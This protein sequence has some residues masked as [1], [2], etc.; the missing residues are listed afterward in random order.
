ML[1]RPQRSFSVVRMPIRLPNAG[2]MPFGSALVG[3]FVLLLISASQPVYGQCPP[4]PNPPGCWTDC[5]VCRGDLNADGLLNDLDLL[6]FEIYQAQSPPNPCANFNGNCDAGGFPIVDAFDRQILLCIINTS[7]GACEAACGLTTRDCLVA[8]QPRDKNPGGCNNP[9]CCNAVCLERPLCCDVLWDDLCVNAAL[10]LCDPLG[11]VTRPDAGDCLCEHTYALPQDDCILPTN[12]ALPGC[13]DAKCNQLVCECDPA[14]CTILWD[15]SCRA[16]ATK[17]CTEA[18]TNIV[19]QEKVC[20]QLPTCCTSGVWDAPCILLAQQIIISNPGLQIRSFP[21]NCLLCPVDRDFPDFSCVQPGFRAILCQI[22]PA[23][24]NDIA[25]DT[26]VQDCIETVL[27]NFEECALDWDAGCAQIADRLCR[28]PGKGGRGNCLLASDIN[29]GC[30]DSYCTSIV[31]D[32]DPT[33]CSVTWDQSCVE[34]AGT[35]CVLVPSRDL[36]VPDLILPGGSSIEGEFGL[37]CGADSA[38]SCLYQNFTP[39]C[40][41]AACCQLVCGYDR[42]CCDSRWDTLCAKLATA[43]CDTTGSGVCGPVAAVPIGDYPPPAGPE[44]RSCFTERSENFCAGYPGCSPAGCDNPDCCNNVCYVDPYCCEIRW[45]QICADGADVLC[46]QNFTSCG[47]ILSGSCFIPHP[48]PYCDNGRCC[49]NVCTIE[50]T[51]CQVEWDENCVK[52][53]ET[54]CTQCGDVYSGSCLIPHAAP[55]CYDEECCQAVCEIDSFCCTFTWDSGCANIAILNPEQ[56]GRTDACGDPL[57]RGCYISSYLPGC[58]DDKCCTDICKN[59]DPWC[60]EVRWDAVCAAQAFTLCDPPFFIDGRDPCDQPSTNQGC[61]VPQCSAAVCSVPGYESCCTQRWDAHCVEAANWLCTGIYECP[62]TGDCMQTN[63]TPLCNDPACCNAVCTYD[64]VCCREVWDNDCVV[65]ALNICITPSSEPD[66]NCPCLGSCFEGREKDEPSPGCEDASCCS[67]VCNV[68][69]SCCTTNWDQECA[70]YAVQFCGGGFQCGSWTSGS[71]LEPGD[72]PFCNDPACCQAVCTIEPFCCSNSWDSFCVGYAVTRC[73]RGCGLSTSG[74][75]Y[76]PHLTP[77]CNEAECCETVCE[78]DPICCSVAWD[79]YCTEEALK[80]CEP[81]ECGTFAAGDCCKE[82]LTPSC[83]DLRCCNAI[84]KVDPICCDSTWDA[85]CVQLARE[86]TVN[87]ECSFEC[88]EPCAG[89]CCVPNFT[90]AC[91]DEDCCNAV[92]KEDPFCCETSWDFNCANSVAF[93]EECTNV[94]GACPIPVCGEA[95]SGNCCFPNGTPYCDDLDCCEMI[96]NQDPS[97]CDVAWDSICAATA[98]DPDIGCDICVDDFACGDAGSGD[99]CE[100]HGNPYCDDF[101][102]CQLVCAF[103]QLC[104]IGTWDELCV[105]LAIQNCAE[106]GGGFA[107]PKMPNPPGK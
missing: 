33:C 73:L 100:E 88:G 78:E 44:Y 67:A 51:C 42:F 10:N 104:C 93:Y 60:C 50:P 74:S 13:S 55:A 77:G 4:A 89:S 15:D 31:C 23:Y 75:C 57:S 102:C 22:D 36:A 37:S 32:C 18:C 47:F 95:G 59:Y 27:I 6:I 70:D 26:N 98:S 86:D 24:C 43:A 49:E 19:L 39:F 96:C 66:W 29:R 30:N 7:N 3:L 69:P 72:T 52:L 83:N 5:G 80:L 11:P 2:S 34:L 62:G 54:E 79:G 85:A 91:N 68:D 99:C 28:W 82:S 41:N 84:C 63:S 103:D 58:S 87:C 35:H 81:P 97:C 38:N 64:P 71:C 8:A 14:C 106:C 12:I 17:Y 48:K 9:T 40:D 92:C 65:V 46:P 56:C 107:P 25:F 20:E 61:N 53:A 45:D 76:F 21:Q 90:P 1:G 101:N 94:D 16:L 105:A